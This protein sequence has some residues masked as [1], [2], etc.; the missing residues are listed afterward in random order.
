MT[1]RLKVAIG[2][3]VAFLVATAALTTGALGSGSHSTAGAPPD[4]APSSHKAT[5]PFGKTKCKMQACAWVNKNGTLIAATK[6][7]VGVTRAS[8][9]GVYCVQLASKINATQV[10]FVLL[11]VDYY[12]TGTAQ[13][14]TAQW[15]SPDPGFNWCFG[16][17]IAVKTYTDAGT[18]VN[19]AFVIAIP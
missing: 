14:V 18:L 5:A 2:L 12:N 4:L 1:V 6:A 11:T 13:N 15:Y 3:A 17:E 19:A 10:Q 9:P 8:D 7:V 16:N